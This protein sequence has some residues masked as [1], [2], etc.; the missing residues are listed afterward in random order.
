MAELIPDSG[1]SEDVALSPPNLQGQYIPAIDQQIVTDGFGLVT[2][3]GGGSSVR[4]YDSYGISES[5]SA[6]GTQLNDMSSYFSAAGGGEVTYNLE[7]LVG[8]QG[9]AGA[10]GLPGMPGK[11]GRDGKDGTNNVVIGLIGLGS[12]LEQIENWD[13]AEDTIIY[14]GATHTV[15]Y[16]P[17]VSMPVYNIK[18]WNDAAIDE[19]GSF[20]IIASDSGIHVSTDTGSSWS[21]K[22]PDSE[23]FIQVSISDASGNAV[24]LGED[25]KDEGK[26]WV[27]SDYGANWSQVTVG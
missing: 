21:L 10:A 13:A 2:P 18:T 24:V 17:W 8:P 14:G 7:G 20:V 12:S 1:S 27:S 25:S 23:D 4:V 19:D 6:E 16:E 26:I 5:K 9:V 3:L 22:T 15:W 11:D